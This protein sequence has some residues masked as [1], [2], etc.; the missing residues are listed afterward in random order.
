MPELHGRNMQQVAEK[1]TFHAEM[2]EENECILIG[3]QSLVKKTVSC[4]A[5]FCQNLVEFTD[6]PLVFFSGTTTR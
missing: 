2:A 4:I 1:N 5:V 6:Y 3:R